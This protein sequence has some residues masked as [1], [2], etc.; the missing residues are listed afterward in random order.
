MSKP[1]TCD[2]Y[3]DILKAQREYSAICDA[4][5]AIEKIQRAL[6]IVSASDDDEQKCKE[7]E[8][9]ISEYRWRLGGLLNDLYVKR[10]SVQF[11]N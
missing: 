9:I 3:A 2:I 8:N 6:N 11:N 5:L 10:Y 7:V 4:T 1:Q